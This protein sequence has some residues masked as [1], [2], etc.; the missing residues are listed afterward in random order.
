M[1]LSTIFSELLIPWQPNLVWWYIIRSQNVLWKTGLLH[2]GSRSQW[3]VKIFMFFQM[4]SSKPPNIL[5]PNLVLW[6][7]IMS[8]SVTQK[9]WLAI[10][11]VRVT[12]RALMTKVWQFL[13]YLL[14][15]W[16]F[17]Y[18]ARVFYGEIWLLCSGS[19][20]Q[21]NFKMSVNVCPDDIFWIA[22]PLTTKLDMVMHL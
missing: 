13:L 7:I 9:D 17:C 1:T 10:F 3:K 15:C 22:E 8:W 11:K 6:C 14:N 16:S 12:A 2:S 4:I 21:Q 20:S 5:F 19:R 18:Q